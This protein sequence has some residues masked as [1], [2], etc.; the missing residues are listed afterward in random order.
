MGVA[1]APR[2]SETNSEV[3]YEKLIVGITPGV[4]TKKYF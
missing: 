2:L 1:G 3:L 4:K